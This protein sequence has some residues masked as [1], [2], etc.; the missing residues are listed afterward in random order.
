MMAEPAATLFGIPHCD[1]V[2]RARAWFSAQGLPHRLHD[3]ARDGVPEAL[4]DEAVAAFGWE[5]VLNRAGTTWRRLDE[6]ERAA[7]VDAASAKAVLLRT[8]SAIKRPLVRW[9]DGG[10]TLGFDAG[11]FAQ[12]LGAPPR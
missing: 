11:A 5:R 3:Y 12:R 10:L 1:S 2:R 4:L 7:V 8:P 6:A 9:P